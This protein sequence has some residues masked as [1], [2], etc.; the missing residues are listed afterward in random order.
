MSEVDR[1]DGEDPLAKIIHEAIAAEPMERRLYPD[2]YVNK[3]ADA[4]REAGVQ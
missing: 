2:L 4:I 1:F 3:I